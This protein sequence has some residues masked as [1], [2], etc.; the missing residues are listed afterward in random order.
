MRRLWAKDEGQNPTGSFKA[1]GLS[2]AITRAR[3]LGARGFVIPSAGNA[4][5][6]A[7]VYGARAGLPVAGIVPRGAPPP[8]IAQAQIAGA[9][10]F[11]PQG[12]I[13]TPGGV[14]PQGAPQLGS[15]G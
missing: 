11:T 4:G 10:P 3:T 7:A 12:P 2:M 9:P 8:P 1:R 5:G 15:V 13:L 14:A 6:A